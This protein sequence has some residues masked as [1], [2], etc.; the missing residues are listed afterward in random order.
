[1]IISIYSHIVAISCGHIL[2]RARPHVINIKNLGHVCVGAI[3][4]GK[5]HQ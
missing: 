5:A 3:R 4:V 1:M 2:E